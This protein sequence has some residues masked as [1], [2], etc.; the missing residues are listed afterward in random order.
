M[1]WHYSPISSSATS[2]QDEYATHTD[3]IFSGIWI[4][5]STLTQSERVVCA[6]IVLIP[7]WWLWGWSYLSVVLMLSI[8]VYQISHYG[9]LHL[10]QSPLFVIT[11]IVFGI[12]ETLSICFWAIY[13]GY[14]FSLPDILRSPLTTWLAPMPVLWY[15]KSHKIRVRLQVVAWAFSVV[16]VQMLIFWFVIYFIGKQADYTPSRSLFGLLTGKGEVFVPGVGN[17]NY[18]MPYFASDSSIA[19]MVRYIF[20]FHGPESLALV[21]GFISLLA[22]DIKQKIWSVLLFSSSFFLLILSGTRSLWVCFP[23]VLSLRWLLTT[24]K[25]GK[26]WLVFALIAI[27]SFTTLSIPPVNDVILKTTTHTAKATGE[28]RGDSTEVRA[29]IYRQ[30]WEGFVN[31]S[32]SELI[33]GH[34]V[35]G[36]TVLP[37]YDPARVGSHSFL[38][39]TLLYR[40]GLLGTGLFYHFGYLLLLGFMLREYLDQYVL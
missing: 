25:N 31:A 15:I 17:S 2:R 22:L 30:T 36:E 32:D 20:F 18:L 28:L 40:K 12:Q 11:G 3:S 34:V 39:S 10:Q 19:G 33:F 27:V 8:F 23:I 5:W 35:V 1:K 37:G 26:L 24:G 14:T 13:N 6:C 9:N 29:E 7:L 16:V 38:L 4:R 21:V